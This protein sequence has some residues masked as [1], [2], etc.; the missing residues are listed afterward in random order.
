MMACERCGCEGIHAC[1]GFKPAS[2]TEEEKQ[3]FRLVMEK[4]AYDLQRLDDERSIDPGIL[5]TPMDAPIRL[6]R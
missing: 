4:V 1:I 6:H 2:W 3:S 5:N